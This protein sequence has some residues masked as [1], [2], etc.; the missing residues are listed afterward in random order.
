MPRAMTM[1]AFIQLVPG[2]NDTMESWFKI[3]GADAIA[4]RLLADGK[5]K[6]CILTTSGLEFMQ[7]GPQMPGFKIRTLRADDYPT[8]TQRRRALVKLL[9]EVGREQA[10][11]FPG[12]GG[13]GFGGGGFGGNRPDF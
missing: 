2:E 10:P 12:F 9:L 11:Q 13:G 3:G 5:T 4:D 7:G 6:P 8:W 1:P